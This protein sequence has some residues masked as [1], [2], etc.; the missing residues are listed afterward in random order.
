[1]E[2][3]YTLQLTTIGSV[4]LYFYMQKMVIINSNR[5]YR[6]NTSMSLVV[7]IVISLLIASTSAIPMF[8]KLFT[9]GYDG[10]VIT[11][12]L[13]KLSIIPILA[14]YYSKIKKLNHKNVLGLIFFMYL[15]HDI[16]FPFYFIHELSVFVDFIFDSTFT[17]VI[18]K[19][20][21]IIYLSLKQ[22]YL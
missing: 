13:L 18:K 1:M 22:N 4:L 6:E 16:S 19:I 14:L 17:D 15:I 21:K 10:F 11:Q 12:L 9:S 2:L 3:L 8:H 5:K 7:F 20:T